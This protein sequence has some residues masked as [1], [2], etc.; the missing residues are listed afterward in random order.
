MY[1]HRQLL[2]IKTGLA[3]SYTPTSEFEDNF[4]RQHYYGTP[5]TPDF[6]I[7][8]NRYGFNMELPNVNSD[9]MNIAKI[10]TNV[11]RQKLCW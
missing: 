2:T 10:L 9:L 8:D 1:L 5:F 4:A 6:G 3:N 7:Q 11:P